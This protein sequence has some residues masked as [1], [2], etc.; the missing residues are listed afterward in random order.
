MPD[1]QDESGSTKHKKPRELTPTLVDE[2]L[3]SGAHDTFRGA[4]HR[5][6]IDHTAAELDEPPQDLAARLTLGGRGADVER[7]P[8]PEADGGNRLAAR[9]NRA[10]QR[11][12]RGGMVQRNAGITS[13][14]N[15]SIDF[16][17][18]GCSMS[19]NQKLQL[20]WVM[21]TSSLMRVI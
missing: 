21:P 1:R 14:A 16:R 9:W 19:P 20:K 3:R 15:S 5:R 8:R 11:R 4:V 7:L 10:H 18:R 12:G 17:M 2:K 13:R 6:R